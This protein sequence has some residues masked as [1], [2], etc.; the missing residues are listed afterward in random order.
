MVTKKRARCSTSDSITREEVQ[1]L[2]AQQ[3]EQ[4]KKVYEEQMENKI[5]EILS[6]MNK[7]RE[8]TDS[9]EDEEKI[10]GLFDGIKARE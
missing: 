7:Q 6:A 9:K 10:A 5:K 1:I 3:S 2:L 8:T 4:L